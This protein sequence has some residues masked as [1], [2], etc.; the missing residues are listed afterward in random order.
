MRLVERCFVLHQNVG[1][2]EVSVHDIVRV[3]VLDGLAEL[4]DDVFGRFEDFFLGLRLQT[5]LKRVRHELHCTV[6]V[7]IVLKQLENVH[8]VRVTGLL[9]HIYL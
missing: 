7:L 4:K 2:F 8:N 1:R 6:N 9:K 3:H 5:V